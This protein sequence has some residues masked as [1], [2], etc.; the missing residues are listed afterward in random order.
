MNKIAF[1]IPYFGVFKNY[2]QLYLNSCGHNADLC[3]WLIFTDNLDSYVYPENIKVYHFTWEQMRRKIMNKLECAT[4]LG[5]PYKLC[6]FRPAYGY[7]FDEYLRGY[8]FWGECDCDLIWG[9]ISRFLTD[10]ILN[11]YDKIFDLGHC[12]IYRNNEK[13]NRLFMCSLN[14]R[15]R[16]KEVYNSKLNCS[17]DEEYKESI[18][19]IVLEHGMR[20]FAGSFAANIYMKSSNF[21]LTTLNDD[22]VHY[23]TEHRSDSVFVWDKGN[24]YRYIKYQNKIKKEEYLYIHLQSRPM[25]IA[26]KDAIHLDR[27]KIIPN[28]FDELEV[29]SIDARTFQTIKKK[30]FNLQYIRLRSKNLMVKIYKRMKRQRI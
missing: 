20:L 17:F 22:K 21:L 3:D 19:S 11:E 16:Y 13:M 10:D 29:A 5:E 9:K 28:S 7:I 26:I 12:T 15:A 1:I 2:F 6:D 8:E 25:K 4:G 30:H 24:L 23:T 18:N 14:G 27:F